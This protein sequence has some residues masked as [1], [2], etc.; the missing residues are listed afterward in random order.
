MRLRSRGRLLVGLPVL[1]TA[2]VA[3][4]HTGEVFGLGSQSSA[5]AGA[6]AATASDF[7]AAYY[8]PAGFGFAP[9]GEFTVGASYFASNLR[10]D[11][12]KQPIENPVGVIIGSV[13]PMEFGGFLK[14]RLT[15]GFAV[16]M[17]PDKLVRV[18][19]RRPGEA[20]F[21]L[22]ENR[23]QR[24]L[25]LPAL[26][27][28][29]HRRVAVGIGF[30]ML[31]ML[32][33]HVVA[34][35]GAT[36]SLAPRVDEQIRTRLTLH[37]GAR[38]RPIDRLDLGVAY[39]QRFSVPYRTTTR[40]TI[41]GEPL[42]LDVDAD[43]LFT[44]HQI[45]GGAAWDFAPGPRVEVDGAWLKWSDFRGPYVEVDASLPLLAPV[46]A[47]LPHFEYRDIWAVRAGAEQ[48]L[49]TRIGT[50]R[51]RAGVHVEPS[52]VPD[53]PGVSNQIDGGKITWALGAGVPIGRWPLRI[54]AH[55]LVQQVLAR[56][57]DKRL[58]ECTWTGTSNDC[59]RGDPADSL[60]DE[61]VTTRGFETSNVGYPSVAGGGQVFAGGLTLTV[62][63]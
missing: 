59:A 12:E 3:L 18:I 29:L 30:N 56:R 53:Q 51:L 36:R 7:S 37:A 28:R 21:P 14:G 52:P 58:A 45:V 55:F 57:L 5:R 23:T 22:Y 24:L 47:N 63:M 42:D 17:L 31:A 19:A 60:V 10:I 39:R 62:E 27:I 15:L 6:V 43:G 4:A 16:Y 25:I 1:L 46:S 8:N 35:E 38:V 32:D 41:A 44:P 26:G 34:R 9:R 61:D 2:R 33:G 49:R 48:G 50:L 54:D 13:H 11:G 20:F 40:N